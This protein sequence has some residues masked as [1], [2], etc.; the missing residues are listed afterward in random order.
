MQ[1]HPRLDITIPSARG[2]L[3]SRAAAAVSSL[4]LRQ[5]S[6][7][8]PADRAWGVW[9][10]RQIVS[11]VMDTFG[12]SLRGVEVTRV[13]T[14]LDD[15]RRVVGE[16]VR[17]SNVTR[18]DAALYYIHGSGYVLCSPRTHRRLTGQLSRL[19][20]L[21]V[22]C[23]DYRLAPEHRF[24]S[25]AVDIRSGWDWLTGQQGLSADRMVIAG[26]SA[27]GHLAV[28]L[29]LQH[30]V[31]HPVALAMFSPLYDLT[32]RLSRVRETLHPDPAIRASDAQKMIG[33]Y[34]AQTDLSDPRLTLNVAGGRVM[35]PTLIQ[36]GSAEMLVA[37]ART[38]A[39]DIRAAGGDCELQVFADQ[40]HVFQALPKISSEAAPALRR[41]AE[42]LTAAL[43]CRRLER[44]VS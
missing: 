2:S 37:D 25:A 3:R 34:C 27:G 31:D 26:D 6:S 15:G 10:S 12:A 29:L 18:S 4:T 43:E 9:A 28:G 42:F 1:A 36:A 7:V 5:I 17:A 35:P 33:L 30:D 20:G 21:P 24:P 14:R 40:V 16:W 8:L 32:F 11:R 41:A 38:L 13:D 19:T 22:F 39:A 44:A 23:I